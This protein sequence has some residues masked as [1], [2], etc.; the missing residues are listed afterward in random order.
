MLLNVSTKHQINKFKFIKDFVDYIR[1]DLDV[2]FQMSQINTPYEMKYPIWIPLSN[3][4]HNTNLNF[5]TNRI[6][7]VR[8][9][10]VKMSLN[11]DTMSD[12]RH[13]LIV[14]FRSINL[15]LV[16][17]KTNGKIKLFYFYTK[18]VGNIEDI[19]IELNEDWE[20]LST[21]E[22]VGDIHICVP[23]I[24]DEFIK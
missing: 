21:L 10:F 18:D 24:Y 9:S 11:L 22:C 8:T 7:D 19:S 15:K 13:S 4:F 16:F 12:T 3:N 17:I 1:T 20:L 6:E 5:I 23:D 14:H 2:L